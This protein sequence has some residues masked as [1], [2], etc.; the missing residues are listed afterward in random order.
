MI[1]Q[2][3][4]GTALAVV[5]LSLGPGVAVV[6]ADTAAPEPKDNSSI[7][8]ESLSPA[9][10]PAKGTIT[11]TGS[12]HNGSDETWHHLS[13]EP[14]TSQH[15]L[16]STDR[17]AYYATFDPEAVH[18]GSAL[19]ALRAS[20]PDLAPGETTSFSLTIPR[21]QLRIDGNPG[22]YWLGVT[23]HSDEGHPASLTARTYLPL[24]PKM[25]KAGTVSISLVVPLRSSPLR[26]TTG[27]VAHAN[28]FVKDLGPQGRLGRIA[29]FG[30]AAAGRPLTWLVDPALLDLADQ[31]AA[32]IDDYALSTASATP[33][34]DQPSGQPSSAASPQHSPSQL[35]ATQATTIRSWLA[36]VSTLIKASTTYALP[37]G[38]PVL[39][40][41]IASGNLTLLNEALTLS[42]QSMRDRG[43]TSKPGV[44]PPS[45][46][47]DE[48]TWTNLPKGQTAF[49]SVPDDSDTTSVTARHRTL[50]VASAASEGGPGPVDNTSALNLRQR[51]LAEAALS[52]K[53]A[54]HTRLTV[55]LPNDWDP[56]TNSAI[57]T[58]FAPLNRRWISFAGIQA[59]PAG[60]A[61][62][63]ATPVEITATQQQAINA[64]AQLHALSDSLISMVATSKKDHAILTRQLRAATLSTLSASASGRQ[65][66]YTRNALLTTQAFDSLLS[67]VRVEGTKFVTLSGSSGVIT[68]AIYN[69]L[70]VPVRLGLQQTS[71]ETAKSVHIDP[72]KPVTLDPGERTTL[73]LDVSAPRVSVQ[74]VTLSAVTEAGTPVGTPLTYTVRSSSVGSVVWAVTVGIVLL[75]AL[76]AIRGIRRRIATRRAAE[77]ADE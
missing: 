27:E 9:V 26:T 12:L 39:R 57:D 3:L 48:Q 23:P 35:D 49:V 1:G 77:E 5:A 70:D 51:L 65:A 8:L 60:K 56:G 67:T 31:T 33:S 24:L 61:T 30:N 11:L 73:R 62:L 15:P 75:I 14:A 58:F 13:V 68:V 42:T 59:P 54:P 18:L 17:V 52:A 40:P 46:T 47:L 21:D 20:L 36:S 4:L 22:T 34:S 72:A 19:P 69:G 55:V 71:Y 44:A 25:K 76:M 50:I 41:L 7:R 28:A 16:T 37:Y 45:G 43:M 29:N 2:R 63:S 74:E 64:A 53:A 38:D 10:I 32:G 6:H 66:A